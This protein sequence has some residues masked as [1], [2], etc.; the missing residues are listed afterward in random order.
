MYTNTEISPGGSM[1]WF[2]EQI[3]EFPEGCN[4]DQFLKHQQQH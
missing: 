3:E 1:R 2:Q 4:L